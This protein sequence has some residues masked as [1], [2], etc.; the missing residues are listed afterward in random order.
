MGIDVDKIKQEGELLHLRGRV[1]DLEQRLRDCVTAM[2]VWGSWEDGVPEAGR[3]EHGFVGNAYDM[4][5]AVLGLVETNGERIAAV[6]KHADQVASLEAE[7][8]R[9][10]KDN[11]QLQIGL[12]QV[13]P[14]HKHMQDEIA[15]LKTPECV[16]GEAERLLREARAS[17][18][19]LSHPC[20]AEYANCCV[21][22]HA[23]RNGEHPDQFDAATLAEAFASMRG[24]T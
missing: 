8:V 5:K 1:G 3:G 15:R 10:H 11:T 14:L 19:H 23:C 12:D 20:M 17:T 4:A 18:V 13:A 22:S 2:T 9:L 6:V 16:L 21:V 7:I 24:S